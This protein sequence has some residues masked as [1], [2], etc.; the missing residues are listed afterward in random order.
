[1]RA[2][3]G[4]WADLDPAFAP[5]VSGKPCPYEQLDVLLNGVAEVL[6]LDGEN[7]RLEWRYGEVSAL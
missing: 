1:M 3:W 2:G 6:Y 4:Q 5:R 7:A